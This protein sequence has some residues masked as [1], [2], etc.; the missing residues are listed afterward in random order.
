MTKIKDLRLYSNNELIAI[1]RGCQKVGI[2]KHKEGNST[3]VWNVFKQLRENQKQTATYL[4]C[5][6]YTRIFPI[7]IP[8]YEETLR[9]HLNSLHEIH[10]WKRVPLYEKLDKL[11]DIANEIETSLQTAKDTMLVAHENAHNLTKKYRNGIKV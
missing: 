9:L 11:I 8:I 10:S 3:L 1:L 6:Y 7:E 2:K 5:N 4:N